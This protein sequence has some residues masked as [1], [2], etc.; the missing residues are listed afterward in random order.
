MKTARRFPRLGWLFAIVAIAWPVQAQISISTNRYDGART[1]ANLSETKL[2][3]SNVNVNN[4]GKLYT[5]PVDGSVYAQPLYI[6]GVTIG[7]VTRNVLY[8]ATMNDKVYAFDAD[9]P[10]SSPLWMRDFTSPPSVTPVPITDLVAANKNIVGNIGI[11]STPVIDTAT[12]TIYLLARTKENGA[13]VQRLHALDIVTGASRSGSPVT[14]TGSVSGTAPDATAGIVTFNPKMQSQ[15]AALALSNG[16]VLIAWAGHEDVPP[17]HGWVMGYDAAT[18]AQ[19]ATFSVTPDAYGGGIWQGGRAP[20][21]DAAGNVYFVT[22]NGRWDGSRN[23]GNSV[24]KFGVSRSGLSLLDFFTPSNQDVL[25]A[26]DDDLSGSSF[27]LLPGTNLLLGGGK[28]GV[29]Y[30]L[31]ANNLGR[32]APADAQIPQRIDVAGGHVMGGPVFW[33]AATLG[34]MIYHWAEDDVLKAYRFSGGR[35]ALPPYAQGPVASPGHP[36]GS[37]TVSA[38]GNATG[39]GIVWSSMPTSQDGIHGLVP[40][41]L[42]AFNAETLNEIWNSEQNAARDRAGTLMKFVPPVVV[43]GRVY[44]PSHDNAVSVYGLLPPGSG[45]GP[46]PPGTIS[47]DFVGSNAASMAA[48]ETAGAMPARNWNAAFGAARSTPQAL[49]DSTGA[50]TS[51]TVIWSATGGTWQLPTT[52][53]AGSARMMKGYLDTTSTTGTT[54]SV[55]GLPNASYDVY[56]YADGDNK[57]YERSASYTIRGPG[58]TTTTIGVTDRAGVNFGGTF[59]PAANSAGNYVRFTIAATGFTVEATPTAPESGTRRAPINGIQIVPTAPAQP[60]PDFMITESPTARTVTPGSSATYTI[61]V[62]ALNG[63]TGTVSLSASGMPAGSTASF[64]PT[65][66][67][68]SGNSTLTLTT[69]ASTP[70][71]TFTVNVSGSSGGTTRS[72]HVMLTVQAAPAAGAGTISIDF[73]GSSPVAMGSSETA[74]VIAKAHWNNA[75]GPVRT[76]PQTLVDE[77]GQATGATLVWSAPAGTWVLPVADQPGSIRMMN[78]YLDTSSTSTSSLTISG[79]AQGSYDVYVYADGDN[80]IY[81]RGAAYSVSGPGISAM[82]IGLVDAANANF[83][84][85]FRLAN[86]SPG[87]YVRFSISGTGFTVTAAPTTPETGTRRAP[88]NGI[89]IVPTSVAP[90]PAPIGIDFSGSN[91]TVMAAAESAGVVAQTN[92]NNAAGAVRTS[93]QVLVDATGAATAA[94]VTWSANGGWAIPITDSPGNFRLMRGY[95]DTSSTSVSTVVVSGLATRTY[96]VYVYADGDN[97]EY[98]RSATYRLTAGGSTV[99]LTLTDPASTNFS[100]TFVQASGGAGNYVKFTISAG[101]F[102]VT[103]TPSTASSSNLRAPINAIQIVPRN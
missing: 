33:N 14:I 101:E 66:I 38:N 96:D 1:G 95:L 86:G 90:P 83:T 5:Y 22:G 88:I 67:T 23:F 24:L 49:V 75:F 82:T 25:N 85:V 77:S 18:L 103:A 84:G 55:A 45:T 31:D 65:T 56:V 44:M 9:S 16:V 46:T 74:G 41:I 58:I 32:M 81:D 29:L 71:G 62:A 73:V 48:S 57:I 12:G 53:Q 60:P 13:Y 6:P 10:S 99:S 63:F 69:A 2:T 7:G 61:T 64:S 70:T 42:R 91:P 35:L 98:S 92:W 43:N 87:N 100:G 30:L 89:Q 8:V 19:V 97:R 93:P 59:T 26:A 94:S 39:T 54:V 68:G 20:T 4:F 79:L 51:A 37:L 80:K 11:Q 17:Y 76:D 34:P 72:T 36:G 102:T 50:G 15:R 52:D 21:L 47:V 27:T 78:G 28:E 40:G 3:T